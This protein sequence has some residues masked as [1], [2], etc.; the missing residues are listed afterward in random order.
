MD[1]VSLKGYKFSCRSCGKC[2]RVLRKTLMNKK[3]IRYKYDYRGK[4]S[5]TPTTSVT[6]YYDE[7]NNIE[8]YFEKLSSIFIPYEALFLKD[9]PFEFVYTYQLKT[10]KGWCIFY[11]H[12]K[13]K[14]KIYSQRPLICKS[15][16]L[17][18]DILYVYGS[19]YG[20]IP[21]VSECKDVDSVIKKRYQDIDNI[22]EIKFELDTPYEN[23]FPNCYENCK[24]LEYKTYEFSKFLK[25]WEDFIIN[26]L[27][28]R[29]DM[30]KHYNQLDFSQFWGWIN[31]NKDKLDR[32]D[33]L[34]RIRK[35]KEEINQLKEKFKA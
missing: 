3:G 9:Y 35:Y 31:D 11:D 23:I 33:C 19:P 29:P 25:I 32:K 22:M 34:L 17:Y 14:C 7:K 27:E 18:I 28:V 6:V 16:P 10:V 2:C 24:K 13:K 15:Y 1:I 21:N 20:F 8:S 5:K 4:L 30:V 12:D 26:P